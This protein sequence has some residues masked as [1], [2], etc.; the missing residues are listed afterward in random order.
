[1]AAMATDSLRQPTSETTPPSK[2]APLFSKL[3]EL[4]SSGASGA[5]FG[6]EGSMSEEDEIQTDGVVGESG[7]N[8]GVGVAMSE[9][10]HDRFGVDTGTVMSDGWPLASDDKDGDDDVHTSAVTPACPAISEGATTS[11]SSRSLSSPLRT[12]HCSPLPP[13]LSLPMLEADQPV[14]KPSDPY[15]T[16]DEED[17]S[18]VDYCA[19]SL[20]PLD[21]P[22]PHLSC[23]SVHC[24]SSHTPFLLSS[25]SAHTAKS[26]FTR[27]TYEP[28]EVEV[29][30]FAR[31]FQLGP[32]SEDGDLREPSFSYVNK[33]WRNPLS[34]Q[35]SISNQFSDTLLSPI[36]LTV[37]FGTTCIPR[38]AFQD[39]EFLLF[40]KQLEH[41]PDVSDY[42]TYKMRVIGDR[43]EKRYSKELNQAMDEIFYEVLKKNLS[44]TT[45]SS[46]SRRLLVGGARIQDGILLVPCFARRLM[47]L[48]PNLSSTIG[49]YTEKILDNYASDSILGMG[50]WVSD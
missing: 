36:P 11:A 6:K 8:P 25:L 26:V 7:S 44:W 14:R 28:V 41:A 18:S 50:G 31:E 40:V 23:S 32:R 5:C 22:N 9:M 15:L 1:M 3:E 30:P 16:Y 33:P 12:R 43:I 47:D 46:A 37:E 42:I 20:T 21:K 38:K 4:Q 2:G 48:V 24:I 27:G 13:P 17:S 34:P 45:F 29:N 39:R 35:A 49:Q 19:E 10:D